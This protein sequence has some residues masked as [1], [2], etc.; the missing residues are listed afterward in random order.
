MRLPYF[1]GRPDAQPGA[2]VPH[3]VHEG[4]QGRG[5]DRRGGALPPPRARPVPCPGCLAYGVLALLFSLRSGII[6]GMKTPAEITRRVPGLHVLVPVMF[7]PAALYNYAAVFDYRFALFSVAAAAAGALLA[8]KFIE[9]AEPPSGPRAMRPWFAVWLG[10]TAAICL[11]A[12]LFTTIFGRYAYPC[13]WTPFWPTGMAVLVDNPITALT[14]GLLLASIPA[15]LVAWCLPGPARRAAAAAAP[16][17]CSDL[18]DGTSCT[19]FAHG[20]SPLIK[21]AG[22]LGPPVVFAAA[23]VLLSLRIPKGALLGTRV[24]PLLNV[25]NC[26]WFRKAL[27]DPDLGIIR[28]DYVF[29]PFGVSFLWH[30]LAPLNC[31]LG[32]IWQAIT[33]AGLI[34]TYNFLAMFSFAMMGWSGYLL[35]RRIGCPTVGFFVGF[36]LMFAGSHMGQLRE[37]HLDL[38]N[39]QWIIFFMLFILRAFEKGA[40]LDAAAAG[41]FWTAAFYTHFYH[42]IFCGMILAIMVLAATGRAAA[43]SPLAKDLAQSMRTKLTRPLVLPLLWITAAIAFQS[44]W[45]TWM[46]IAVAAVVLAAGPW[47]ARTFSRRWAAPAMISA[48]IFAAASAPWLIAMFLENA[49]HNGS[50]D[51]GRSPNLYSTDLL[52]YLVPCPVSRGSSLFE[53]VWSRFL[54]P[55]GDSS[56]F[57]G[58]P[59]IGLALYGLWRNRKPFWLF[60]AAVF[61]VVSFGPKLHVAGQTLTN[62]RLPYVAI[63]AMPFFAASGVAG[64]YSMVATIAV[65]MVAAAGLARLM[66]G[67]SAGSPVWMTP[68]RAALGTAVLLAVLLLG[69]PPFFFYEPPELPMLRVVKQDR[70]PNVVLPLCASDAALWFQ[71][72]HEKKMF[73][74]FASRVDPRVDN[75][76]REAPVFHELYYGKPLPVSRE[77]ALEVLRGYGVRWIIVADAR[78]RETVERGL[79]L[80]PVAAEK[81]VYLYRLR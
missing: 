18:A 2:A 80:E 50:L 71:T 59:V 31:I 57:L 43:Q 34:G 77:E 58:F 65:V 73:N 14:D 72:I 3:I 28:T 37:G 11:P 53:T 61:L 48:G 45:S 30:T 52:G 10:Y 62:A 70:E 13:T 1:M 35:G 33:G 32:I 25:W 69:Y 16:D 76:I 8:S 66:A 68:K 56:A 24:D 21:L 79:G 12:W 7:V 6:Q 42:G 49:A 54:I 46:I 5:R 40:K 44:H 51:W 55:C 60:M 74:G 26:W 15:A 22:H 39:A 81:C 4:G 38:A 29:Q 36:S 27:F 67:V 47:T 23:A 19:L 78:P 9:P 17:D 75:F 41:I 64:R 63:D 20:R